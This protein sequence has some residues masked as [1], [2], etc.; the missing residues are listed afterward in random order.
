MQK[1]KQSLDL[2]LRTLVLLFGIYISSA[3]Y[4]STIHSKPIYQIPCFPMHAGDRGLSSNTCDN[5]VSFDND[6]DTLSTIQQQ[7]EIEWMQHYDS[8]TEFVVIN[9]LPHDEGLVG[10]QLHTIFQTLLFSCTLGDRESQHT[11]GCNYLHEWFDY[12][13]FSRDPPLTR[14]PW[15]ICRHDHCS[16]LLM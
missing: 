15:R 5:N 3:C 2:L 4:I 9:Y 1:V 12:W 13:L 7:K 10:L 14:L 16:Y 6:A 11:H 8:W